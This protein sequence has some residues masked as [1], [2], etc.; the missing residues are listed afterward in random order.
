[1]TMF[2]C[3]RSP[4]CLIRSQNKKIC[5][6]CQVAQSYSEFRDKKKRCQTCGSLFRVPQAWGDIGS[7]FIT[8]MAE[9]ERAHDEKKEII[10][11]EVIAHETAD[12]RVSKTA[13]QQLYEKRL[14]QHRI[15]ATFV[16]RNCPLSSQ[17]RIKLAQIELEQ[18]FKTQRSEVA[19]HG[20]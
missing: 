5:P 8:R 13:K 10:R 2:R 7:D 4:Q 19:E 16:G 1:M 11:S 9:N 17:V 18:T 3:L 6:K 20:Q 15:P 12:G 14:L